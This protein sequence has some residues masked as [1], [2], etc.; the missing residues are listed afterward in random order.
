MIMA[1]SIRILLVD[2]D[3]EVNNVLQE[4]LQLMGYEDVVCA[5]NGEE[6]VERYEAFLPDLVFMDIEMPVMDGLDAC[7]RIRGLDPEARIIVLTGNPADRRV[8]CLLDERIIETVVPKPIRLKHLR[9]LIES[10]S[11]ASP[12]LVS[13]SLLSHEHP[14]LEPLL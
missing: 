12:S 5:R 14:A 7:R 9:T 2:D 8:E 10:R 1:E 6:A 13:P 11:G 3:E 4:A